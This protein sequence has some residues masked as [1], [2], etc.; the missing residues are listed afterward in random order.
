[1]TQ[2]ENTVG[3]RLTGKTDALIREAMR[4]LDAT[5]LSIDWDDKPQRE[6]HYSYIVGRLTLDSDFNVETPL[7]TYQLRPEI[8]HGAGV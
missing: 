4:Q 5:G 3:L 8:F 6:S 7:P 1:M 2:N